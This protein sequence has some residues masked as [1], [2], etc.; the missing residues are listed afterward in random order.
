MDICN[1]HIDLD[2]LLCDI[3]HE[4]RKGIVDSLCFALR[5]KEITCENIKKCETLTFLSDFT[6]QDGNL[7]V[8]YINENG[9]KHTSVVNLNSTIENAL[10]EID[11]SC[12]MDQEEWNTLS[13][14]ERMAAIVDLLC[15]CCI[16]TTT[17]S[18]TTTSTTS[19]TT[20]TTITS[21]T[22]TTTTTSSST[23]TTSS[24][25]TTT[26][27]SSEEF[28]WIA[29]ETACETEGGFGVV[30]TI[31]GL[32]S[33]F[34][35]WYDITTDRLYV[36]DIDSP[37]G[38]IYWFANISTATTVANATFS[39][40]ILF[41]PI[42]NAYFDEQYRRIYL[43]GDGTNGLVVYD[44]DGDSISTVVFGTD[45]AFR[46]TVL[47]VSGDLIMCNDGN[48]NVVLIDRSA[49]TITSIIATGTI[50]HP[51]HFNSG[52]YIVTMASNGNLYIVSNNGDAP[53]VG[54]Y[55]TSLTHIT[56]I[57]LPS[58]AV[59]SFSNYWQSIFY[60][61]T[62]D[63][64]YV[65]DSGSNS[66]YVID[67]NTNT[68]IF[69]RQN[70]NLSGKTNSTYTFSLDPLSNTLY[71][72]FTAQNSSSDGS[73]VYRMYKIDRNTFHFIN[74]YEGSNLINLSGVAPL[75]W[76]IGT[77]Q[78]GLHFAG[79]PGY[80]TDGTLIVLSN[81]IGAS[82]TGTLL[83]LTLQEVT[84]PGGIPTGD[85][86]PNIPS[87]PDYIQPEEM[88][89]DCSVD[90]SLD[91]P[92]DAVTT[93]D[94]SNNTYYEFSI[95]N[96]VRFNPAIDNIILYVYETNSNTRESSIFELYTDPTVSNF[97]GGN[98]EGRASAGG[99]AY[100]VE[101]VYRDSGNNELASCVID[102]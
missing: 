64:L 27:T 25:T 71:L 15:P 86:K 18:T 50:T 97:Y 33:P 5:P 56:E 43:V 65:G 39:S 67:P 78:A 42:L 13:N 81:T 84:S 91:C 74:M 96:S 51:E 23:T 85:T 93:N 83:T 87:D 66:R 79:D 90:V 57:I 101:V 82:N 17:T 35:T 11:A 22:T 68:V 19:T 69:S 63:K 7:S 12:L 30:K 58:A 21:T 99:N 94:G 88:S 2:K 95:S 100:S 102:I 29:D 6:I 92:V 76:F 4:W 14:L 72:R 38:N 46:R 45:G 34:R 10:D 73:P 31:T 20:T 75:G 16:T 77:N 26:T 24:S 32:S 52:P 1:C 54:V 89:G 60:D 49:L 98:L 41:D 9:T 3:P 53:S 48:D 59:W 62:S 8:Y 37:S 40:T 28:L 44:I 47:F 80:A 36:A 55:N 70:L 61:V